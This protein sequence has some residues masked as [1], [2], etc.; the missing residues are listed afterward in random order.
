MTNLVHIINKEILRQ[1]KCIRAVGMDLDGN[2]TDLH[3]PEIYN[4]MWEN[5]LGFLPHN[6]RRQLQRHTFDDARQIVEISVGCVLDIQLGYLVV[7]GPKGEIISAKKGSE[8]LTRERISEIYGNGYKPIAIQPLNPDYDKPRFLPC[9]DGFDLVETIA[10]GLIAKIGHY[11]RISTLK[12][13]DGALYSSHHF[14]NGFKS[15]LFKHPENYGIV[16]D[17][18][19]REFLKNL[20]DAYTT[21]LLT[22]SNED[23][24]RKILD[25][26][27]VSDC[28]KI[29][30]TDAKKPACF[31]FGSPE[32]RILLDRFKEAGIS[33]PQEVFYMGDHLYKD[34]IL[35]NQY[36]FFTGLRM[37]QE[38]ISE[39][40][41]KLTKYAGVEFKNEGKLMV[42]TNHVN[43]QQL[44]RL[45]NFLLHIYKHV[46][47]LA[48]KVQ[49]LEPILL[50]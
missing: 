7:V 2:L 19:K 22:N 5:M 23:Y 18:Q 8:H 50:Y 31:S 16:P 47:V 25:A 38:D 17:K 14:E 42:P 34:A 27:G 12:Q 49:N 43:E 33:S 9:C 29:I 41:R 40:E 21:F 24:A 6:L 28:F 3:R 11:P 36:G 37:K 45:S 13:I 32:N 46:N 48:T 4:L 35:A 10:K 1:K 20:N 30:I 15:L 26:L 39:L 44:S